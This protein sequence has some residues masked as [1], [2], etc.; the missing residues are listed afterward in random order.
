MKMIDGMKGRINKKTVYK[1]IFTFIIITIFILITKLYCS[2]DA[3]EETTEV[4]P[5][6]EPNLIFLGI[7]D[8]PER[9]YPGDE[10]VVTALIKNT[11]NNQS[12]KNTILKVSSNNEKLT[13][14][15]EDN[16]LF[17]GNV[18]AGSVIKV[19]VKLIVDNRI[20]PG[21]ITVSLT[22]EYDDNRAVHLTSSGEFYVDISF[23][24]KVEVEISAV[25]E[26]MTAGDASL[27][28]VQVINLGAE[29]IYNVR[30]V[31]DI[32]GFSSPVSA[33][34]GDIE[35]RTAGSKELNLKA[36]IVQPE[37]KDIN[38]R[39][40]YTEGNFVVTYEDN[41][42]NEYEEKVPASLT[43]NPPMIKTPDH[44]KEESNL[45]LRQMIIGISIIVAGII[46]TVLLNIR[47]KK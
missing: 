32:P 33:F 35:G 42:G 24:N 38:S 1:P 46:M 8:M 18:Y 4:V 17:V 37:G 30:A 36:G 22:I 19:P 28:T 5:I 45:I 34:I 9:I 16:T 12:V 31:A 3:P 47:R 41:D 13:A 27:T 40:G 15:L 44:E 21:R 20:T 25:P 43:I 39:Y 10:V 7:D 11:S 14:E 26:Y 29:K 2:A 6:F 23:E